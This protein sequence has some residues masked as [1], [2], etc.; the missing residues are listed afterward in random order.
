[1]SGFCVFCI[2]VLAVFGLTQLT[3]KS[4]IMSYPRELLEGWFSRISERRPLSRWP[5]NRIW[6]DLADFP[7]CPT[8]QSYWHA[9]AVT[10]LV[11]DHVLGG[12][13]GFVV[14]WF[15]LAGAAKLAHDTLTRHPPAR[16]NQTV[17]DLIEDI[18]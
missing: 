13:G 15:G 9:L 6:A 3:A 12:I 17:A 2:G 16:G 4:T 1:M 14:C 18:S 10:L 5:L 7:T 11:H 8:C